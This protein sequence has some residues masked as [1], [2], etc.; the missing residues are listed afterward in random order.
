MK[1]IIA[2]ILLSVFA[3][4]SFA[5]EIYISQIGDSLDLDITQTGDNNMIGTSTTDM[6]IE[7]DSMTFAITQVGNTNTIV[8]TIKG[9]TYTGT[10]DF[11]GNN[12]DVTLLCSSTTTGN[13]DN[14]TLNIDNTGDYSDYTISIGETADASGSTI[15]FTI[16]GDNL[17]TDLD[18]N[19]TNAQVTVVFDD[20]TSG[21]TNASG[22][23]ANLTINTSGGGATTG[24][25]VDLD[26]TGSGG[27]Y[28]ITQTQTAID[29][30]VVATFNGDDANVDITQSD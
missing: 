21:L 9:D 20:G 27:T 12:N 24:N 26:I 8:A 7:G 18:V 6:V 14:V 1:K 10:W 3:S 2:S 4:V 15:N 30:K 22:N 13:C 28:N 25:V 29:Q 19:G 16:T 17:V 23:T 11:L 5:N